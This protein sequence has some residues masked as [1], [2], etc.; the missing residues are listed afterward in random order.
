MANKLPLQS[1]WQVEVAGERVSRLSIALRPTHIMVAIASVLVR[2][3]PVA[4]WTAAE[5]SGI[6]VIAIAIAVVGGATVPAIRRVLPC[7]FSSRE[8]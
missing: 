6:L 8:S 5:R 3:L 7:R 1:A 2:R 4:S